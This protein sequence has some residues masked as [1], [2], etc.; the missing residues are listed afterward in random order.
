M[1]ILLIKRKTA[2]NRG[3]KIVAARMVKG[4]PRE[5][6][7]TTQSKTA[8]QPLKIMTLTKNNAT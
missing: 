8:K 3:Q 6:V 7:V 4:L 1:K 5:L 2:E